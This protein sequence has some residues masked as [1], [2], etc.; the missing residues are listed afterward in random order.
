[1]KR[2]VHIVALFSCFLLAGCDLVVLSPAGDVAQQQ[3]ELIIYATVL[4]LIVILPVMALTVFFAIKYRESN[5]KASYEPEWHHSFSL[6]IVIWSVPLAIIICLAGL[7]W[8]ATHRLDPYKPLGRISEDQP[9]DPEVKP[10]IIQVASMDWKWLFIYPEQGIASVN[11]VAAIVDRP[12]EFQITSATVMNSFYIP[13]LAGQIYSMAGMQ[14]EMNAVI[15]E[16]GVYDGF[17]ANYSGAGFSQMRF[18]FHGMDLTGFDDWVAKVG[19]SAQD[20]DTDTL[21]ALNQPSISH[22]VTY[23]GTVSETAWDRLVNHCVDSDSL[24][25]NDMMMVDALG[26]GG[27]EGLWNREMFRGICSAEDPGA[28]I[29]MLRPEMRLRAGEI[30]TVMSLLPDATPTTQH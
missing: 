15:N 22:P 30:V 1:M 12:I 7:T 11:E 2:A 5:K 23:Y 8:V 29:A 25:R 9:I 4:M 6:E 28:F 21:E 17:S 18:K 19:A 14:T 27:L 24:C 20:L 10:L 13:A 3:G 26:G 16:P